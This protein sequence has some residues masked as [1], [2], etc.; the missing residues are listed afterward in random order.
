MSEFRRT[1]IHHVAYACRDVEETRH[2][3][4]DLLDMPLVHTEVKREGAD[5]DWEWSSG[6][7]KP[8]CF[9]CRCRTN[10]V[11]TAKNDGRWHRALH[12]SRSRL[13]YF[14]LLP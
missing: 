6:L 11:S 12:G 14:A 10:R 2:F 9:C 13:V 4:E 8:C 3:Y 5:I 7:G 1:G